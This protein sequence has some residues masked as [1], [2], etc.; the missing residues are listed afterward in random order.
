MLAALAALP[1]LGARAAVF[2]LRKGRK[3]TFLLEFSVGAPT[4]QSNDDAFWK[5]VRDFF[6]LD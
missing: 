6:E 1:F 2:R 5:P 4:W 3:K